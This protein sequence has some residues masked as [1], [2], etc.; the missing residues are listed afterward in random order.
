MNRN[1]YFKIFFI[2]FLYAGTSS[3]QQTIN[4]DLGNAL[5]QNKLIFHP[6]QSVTPLI[7]DNRQGVSS[8]GIVWIKDIEFSTG[9]IDIDLRGK[10]IFQQ[11]FLGIALGLD[12]TTFEAVYFRPF[13]FQS[14][15]PL[16]RN[17]TVQ[18][19]SEPAYPWEKLRDEFPLIYEN[20]TKP[21]PLAN[22]WFHAKI[23]I[24]ADEISVYTDHSSIVSLKV[25]RLN[26]IQ[27]GMLGLWTYGLKGDFA[28]LM[29]TNQK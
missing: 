5:K 29:I 26:K 6:D 19:I 4:Y 9:V 27:K 8:N 22:A 12:T 2:L 13:N 11:S 23:V 1:Y 21:F 15:D 14:K 25:K 7:D 10:D 16:R 28:N 18:Y 24:K 3:A 17:H 20:S